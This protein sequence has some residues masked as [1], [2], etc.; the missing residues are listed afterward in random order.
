MLRGD[1]ALIYKP[2]TQHVTGHPS[3]N[4]HSLRSGLGTRHGCVGKPRYIL[5]TCAGIWMGDPVYVTV[6]SPLAFG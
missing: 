5:K 3:G 1:V 2:E 4:V 6:V